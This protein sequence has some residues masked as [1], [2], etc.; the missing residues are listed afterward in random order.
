MEALKRFKQHTKLTSSASTSLVF[1]A[2]SQ[3]SGTPFSAQ[4][5]NKRLSYA[6]LPQGE[7]K[8]TG[9]IGIGTFSFIL[10]VHCHFICNSIHFNNT[11]HNVISLQVLQKN[12]RVENTTR[13]TPI[14]T[15]RVVKKKKEKKK[16]G[17][18]CLK[19][20]RQ[21]HLIQHIWYRHLPYAPSVMPQLMDKKHQQH[22]TPTRNTIRNK[23]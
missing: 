13:K 21:K 15:P 1:I 7:K 20:G 9:L 8:G 5:C 10:L 6:K 12:Q 11:I 4:I 14:G 16:P 17:N 22:T 23:G 3:K 19:A 2:V 18:G